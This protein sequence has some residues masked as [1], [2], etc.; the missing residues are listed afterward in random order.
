MMSSACT[1]LKFEGARELVHTTGQ[2]VRSPILEKKRGVAT[3]E[4]LITAVRRAQSSAKGPAFRA[5]CAS[6]RTA[7]LSAGF[8]HLDIEPNCAKTELRAIAAHAS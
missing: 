7:C 6:T 3:R 2:S 4:G 1:N 8:I 5:T